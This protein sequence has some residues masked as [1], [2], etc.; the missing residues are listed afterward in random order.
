VSREKLLLE[1]TVLVG[2][3]DARP[4]HMVLSETLD[5]LGLLVV[6]QLGLD[7]VVLFHSHVHPV[8][9]VLILI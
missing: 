4:A 5:S 9:R 8:H 3:D 6:T 2:V 1:D 7:D